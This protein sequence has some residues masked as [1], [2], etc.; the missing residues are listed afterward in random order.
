MDRRQFLASAAAAA[1]LGELRGDQKDEGRTFATPEEAAKSPPEKLA[2]VVGVYAGT[3]VKKPDYLA[4]IDLDPT[5]KTW[6][7]GFN[8]PV[9][10]DDDRPARVRLELRKIE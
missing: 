10:T 6:S 7:L 5:S 1:S 2:Y 8:V 9:D 4:T 3:E